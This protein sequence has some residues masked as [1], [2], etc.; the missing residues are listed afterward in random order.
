MIIDENGHFEFN[1][2]LYVQGCLG[3]IENSVLL[4]EVNM[5]LPL[6]RRWYQEYAAPKGIKDDLLTW[7]VM[8]IP[9]LE[10]SVI[11]FQCAEI[12]RMES[13]R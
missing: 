6:Y 11:K 4:G 8:F 2:F 13:D 1:N 10:Y 7:T 3:V 12:D 9:A 5:Q